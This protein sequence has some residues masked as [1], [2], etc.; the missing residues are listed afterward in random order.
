MAYFKKHNIQSI[1]LNGNNLI[2][3]YNNNSQTETKLIEEWKKE[4]KVPNEETKEYYEQLKKITGKN[5]DNP[6]REREREREQNYPTEIWD[7]AI[8]TDC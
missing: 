4:D 6:E 7:T 3:E 1:T 5:D 2:I 8:R